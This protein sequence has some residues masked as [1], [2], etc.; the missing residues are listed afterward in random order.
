MMLPQH[1]RFDARIE[2]LTDLRGFAEQF[3]TDLRTSKQTQ[4]T[5]ILVLE[6]L[7]TNTVE[8]GYRGSQEKGG[9]LAVWVTLA[10]DGRQI[11]ACYEDAA[12]AYDPFTHHAAPDYSGSPETWKVGGLGTSLVMKLAC[13]VR[14]EY[15][16][17]RNH[18]TFSVPA[19]QVAG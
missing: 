12:P 9:E 7:F 17:G 4:E 19:T 11:K 3:C 6:E 15:R 10:T 14:Y 18:T 5:L 13:D 8:H 16:G 1:R 2:L